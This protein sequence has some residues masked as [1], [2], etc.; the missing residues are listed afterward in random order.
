M[1]KLN[2]GGTLFTTTVATLTKYPDSMLAIMFN[3]E[4]RRAA[5]K[6]DNGN[7]FLDRDPKAFRVI[8]QFL[9]NARL[10]E[11]IVGCGIDQVEWE[12]DYFGLQEILKI[13]GERKKAKKAAGEEKRAEEERKRAE[14]EA[15]K[16]E[17]ENE[18]KMK[19]LRLRS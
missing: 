18:E 9:R 17:R 7:F 14:E 6:D 13:I 16:T 11:D 12:A 5:E 2:V 1:I 10:P 4:R 19:L 8:L 15:R 3:P